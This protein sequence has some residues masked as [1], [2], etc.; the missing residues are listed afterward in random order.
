MAGQCLAQAAAQITLI[1]ANFRLDL[2]EASL[3]GSADAQTCGNCDS[4]LLKDEGG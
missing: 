2:N 3:M 1:L 4:E